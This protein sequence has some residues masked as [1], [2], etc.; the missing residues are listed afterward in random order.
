[1]KIKNITLFF[2][3]FFIF[4]SA[5]A[6]EPSDINE[7]LAAFFKVSPDRIRVE[8]PQN[9]YEL[10]GADELKICLNKA[11]RQRR[12]EI[13][14]SNLARAPAENKIS[15]EL[16]FSDPKPRKEWESVMQI[17]S[18]PDK[19]EA[20]RCPVTAL[21]VKDGSFRM[22]DRWDSS[23]LSHTSGYNCTE[24]GS[25]ISARPVLENVLLK[26]GQWQD[27]HLDAALSPVDG[28][29]Q[30]KI[31]KK[32]SELIRGPNTYNDEKSPFLKFGIYKPTSWEEGH[33]MSCVK[34]R[35]VKI[36]TDDN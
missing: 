18:F 19:G 35:N 32:A 36:V 15:F 5:H 17:H 21:E 20:W 30:M 31:D 16:N 29:F 12:C 1:M 4:A 3:S 13:T 8:C 27:V 34:Y 23:P 26:A 24:A 2:L 25:S 28:T 6:A 14:V 7:R 11:D 33:E 9:S 22:Y 10:T